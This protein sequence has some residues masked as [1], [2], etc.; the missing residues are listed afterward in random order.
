MKPKIYLETTVISYLTSGLSNDLR[1]AA[2]QATTR[3]WWATRRHQFELRASQAV[4]EEAKAGD[5]AEAEKRLDVLQSIVS[6]NITKDVIELAKALV[7]GIPL[8]HKAQADAVH[9]A[10]AAVNGM[11]YLLTW[12]CAHIANAALRPRIDAICRAAGFEPPIICTPQEL[13][14]SEE[15]NA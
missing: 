2:N 8:P 6:V 13:L 4:V 15:H 10:A 14:E 11:D 5:E 1:V 3:E 9:S 7:T 12:N